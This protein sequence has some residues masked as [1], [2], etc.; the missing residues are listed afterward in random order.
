MFKKRLKASRQ[1]IVSMMRH[2]LRNVSKSLQEC[3]NDAFS[4][5]E[6]RLECR[7]ILSRKNMRHPTCL[8]LTL[9][10]ILLRNQY[11]V[12]YIIKEIE[13]TCLK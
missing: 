10:I 2:V 11:R 4:T 8:S 13:I 7:R 9:L 5:R 6:T 1:N 12:T 3:S